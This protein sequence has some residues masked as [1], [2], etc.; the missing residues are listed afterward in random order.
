VLIEIRQD[1]VADA[2]KAAAFARRLKPVLDAALKD[3]GEG[4]GAHQG[5]A[6]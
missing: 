4:A 6:M 3:M 2:P 5:M 1:L